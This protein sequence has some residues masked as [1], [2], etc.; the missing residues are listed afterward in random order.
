MNV[1][2]KILNEWSFRCHDGIVD[3]NNLTKVSILNE[4]LEEIDSKQ[5]LIDLI[6]N[7]ELSS[8]QINNLK[9][10]VAKKTT[11]SDTNIKLEKILAKKGLKRVVPLIIYLANQFDVEDK[12]LDYIE[13][14][15][16]I[17]LENE[18]NLFTLFSSSNLPI[19]F[20]KKLT[21]TTSNQLGAG[22]LT[23]ATLIP[24]AKK[25]PGK[26]GQG[27]IVIG[28]EILE[29]KG[30][31]AIISEWSSKAPIKEA[32]KKI[33]NIDD[34][35]ELDDLVKNDNW[36]IKLEDDL[37]KEDKEKAKQVIKELYPNF[38]IGLNNLRK[39]IAQNYA[40]QYFKNSN[41]TSML[42]IDENT[43][44]Y[45]KLSKED[46]KNELGNSISLSF[47]K[48]V[49]PRIYLNNT[50]NEGAKVNFEDGT[51]TSIEVSYKPIK[52]EQLITVDGKMTKNNYNVYYSLE[53]N[54]KE[55]NIKAAQD[56]L[57]YD[58]DKIDIN[59]LKE[60]ITKTLKN[61][62]NK[63]DY[64]GFL[65]SKGTLNNLLLKVV[66]EI[67]NI[68]DENIVYIK[69]IEYDYIDNAVD[70]EQF[71]KESK[72]IQNA[73]LKYLEKTSK[74]PG[75]YKIRKSGETQ[76]VIIQRLH[77][78][79]NLGLNPNEPNKVLPPI[80]NVIVDCL[81][82]NKTLLIVDDNI[83]NGIDFS[84]IF[85]SID[86]IIEKM[87]EESLKPSNEELDASFQI[88]N[89]IGNPKFKTSTFLQDK[90][91]ELKQIETQFQ[92][93][94]FI[95]NKQYSNSTNSIFGYVLYRLK[96]SDLIS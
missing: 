31:G 27:D 13:A 61:K 92:E 10:Y 18:G 20:L 95:V 38:N 80:F 24:N 90:Y 36:L 28:N 77:S 44:N 53:S 21:Q 49:S 35:N 54:P 3:I 56:A 78:K 66:K 46:F 26:S 41:I 86:Q 71:Q 4:I 84:K 52:G 69:K 51:P 39:S 37:Q 16:D 6:K 83:H 76:S 11:Q 32:F 63:V 42:I 33:Y 43:G 30:R 60:L 25:V 94:K 50:V 85:K 12:L 73:I 7:S 68:S 48:D 81:N 40:D 29:L 14:N 58:S 15:K 75:P 9:R 17:S 5:E 82:N 22:E 64:I 79:Y 2:D 72:T 87:K 62:I 91:K 55:D 65:E 19:D 8:E 34:E 93:R 89:I 1:I 96:D 23:L 70:W 47:N 57:K 74:E 67:Y 45:K 59:E 88:Q